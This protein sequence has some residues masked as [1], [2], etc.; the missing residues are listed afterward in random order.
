MRKKYVIQGL[1][2]VALL[3][4]GTTP[5]MWGNAEKMYPGI[6]VE[7]EN[8]GGFTRDEW[9]QFVAQK[10]KDYGEKEIVLLLGKTK[11]GWK[12]KDIHGAVDEEKTEKIWE[13]GRTGD[14]FFDWYTRWELLIRG[15]DIDLPLTYDKKLLRE[16]VNSLVEKYSQEPK[17]AVPVIDANG[18]VTFT[19]GVPHISLDAQKL[20]DTIEKA[21]TEG[22]YTIQ[23]ETTEEKL[24]TLTVEEAKQFDTVLGVYSTAFGGDYNRS[25]N[26]RLATEAISHHVILS[27]ERFS[28]NEVTG[29]RSPENGY[30]QAPVMVGSRLEPGYG[31][32]VCQVSTTLFNAIL[33]SGLPVTER[34]CHYSPVSYAPTGQ[35]ATVSYGDLDL[36][37]VNSFSHPVYVYAVYQPGQVTCYI[38][39]NETDK[40]SSASVTTEYSEVI[41]HKKIEKTNPAQTE[42]RIEEIGHDGYRTQIR[43]YAAWK[44]GRTYTDTFSSEYEPKDTIISYKEDPKKKVEMKKQEKAKMD[45]KKELKIIKP[46]DKKQIERKIRE[47]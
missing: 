5:F 25:E 17:D 12:L 2:M 47:E 20:Y 37:F 19:E 6:S 15:K 44:D 9:N 18:H 46:N 40:P 30:L 45:R 14:V 41:E 3:V 29:R 33:L 13:I 32:G 7:S 24:P 23:I 39:G 36:C 38:L 26:I 28:F 43:R 10:T 27:G 16:K 22:K 35:D 42:E 8:V 34:E 1:V 21:L 11:D 31:G 4:I